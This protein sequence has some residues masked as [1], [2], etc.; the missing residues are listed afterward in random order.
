M[1]HFETMMRATMARKR[2]ALESARKADERLA[3]RRGELRP[4]GDSGRLTRQLSVEAVMN[5]V[6]HEGPE[7]LRRAGEGYWKDQDRLYFGINPMRVSNPHSMR[8][9]FGRVTW[10]KVYR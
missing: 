7:V 6:D 2:A 3:A 5:A 4:V 1:E 9:R 10:R 8:N